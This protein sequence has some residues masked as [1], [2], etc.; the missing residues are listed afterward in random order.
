MSLKKKKMCF[1]KYK[2]N[3]SKAK[4][5]MKTLTESVKISLNDRNLHKYFD[6]TKNGH[7]LTFSVKM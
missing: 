2:C 4:I 1:I 6:K 3:S 5:C 7:I